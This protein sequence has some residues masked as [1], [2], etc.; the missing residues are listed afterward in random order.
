MQG[1]YLINAKMKG[2]FN[3][4]A[5]TT[6]FAGLKVLPSDYATGIFSFISLEGN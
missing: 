4:G 6:W 3:N 1:I 5:T 2:W